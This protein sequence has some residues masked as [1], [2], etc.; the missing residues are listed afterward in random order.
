MNWQTFAGGSFA[1]DDKY[2]YCSKTDK[3]EYHIFPY[4]SPTNVANHIG[5]HVAFANTK[6]TFKGGGLWHRLG[7][8]QR[9][10]DAQKA[11]ENHFRGESP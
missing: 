4:S 2:S 3:G 11:C 8:F 5:Y 1:A 7:D 10:A 9:L 6:G